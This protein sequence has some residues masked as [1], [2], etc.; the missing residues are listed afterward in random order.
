[1]TAKCDMH[2]EC[3]GQVSHIDS[4]GFVYCARHG[5]VRKQYMRCRKLKPAELKLIL[6]GQ[7]IKRY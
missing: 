1:M 4:S 2:K 3:Q 7:P 5:A 6:S